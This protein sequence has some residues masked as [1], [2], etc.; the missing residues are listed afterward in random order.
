MRNVY[1]KMAKEIFHKAIKNEGRERK[2]KKNE[3]KCSTT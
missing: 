3:K 2:K 1:G